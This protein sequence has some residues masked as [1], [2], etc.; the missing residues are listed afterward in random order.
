MKKNLIDVSVVTMIGN[1]PFIM[2]TNNKYVSEEFD[3]IRTPRDNKVILDVSA[4]QVTAYTGEFKNIT[5]N[6]Q[7]LGL[8]VD[9]RVNDL[10]QR[11]AV[12]EEKVRRLS[13]EI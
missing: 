11:I 3:L 8:Y 7:E 5:V 13:G 1:L 10:K 6:N 2:N 9:E 12:L 4:A